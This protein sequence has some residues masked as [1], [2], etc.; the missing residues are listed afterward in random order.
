VCHAIMDGEAVTLVGLAE[1][2]HGGLVQA[3]DTAPG[4]RRC[5]S[6]A[7]AHVVLAYFLV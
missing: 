5:R 7:E 4:W 2:L 6:R 1:D 3:A